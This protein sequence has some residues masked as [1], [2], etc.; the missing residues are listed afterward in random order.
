MHNLEEHFDEKARAVLA[1]ACELAPDR[2]VQ[3]VH[4]LVAILETAEPGVEEICQ[5]SGMLRE[6]M[7]ARLMR[8]GALSGGGISE[9]A[10]TE[11]LPAWTREALT[12][13]KES[14][15][16]GGRTISVMDLLMAVASS[17][18]M[19]QVLALHQMDGV[20]LLNATAAR[21]EVESPPAWRSVGDYPRVDYRSQG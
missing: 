13:S 5:E 17:Q 12:R 8:L 3:P 15:L 14:A 2:R 1:S 21:L 19:Q 9:A 11:A 6:E 18:M 4:L 10:A 20:R 16:N 7:L